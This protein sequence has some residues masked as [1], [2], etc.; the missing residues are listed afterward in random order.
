MPNS[1]LSFSI[2]PVQTFIES[3]RSVRDLWTGSYLLSWL[4]YH[5]MRPV[6][7][8]SGKKTDWLVFPAIEQHP[9][10]SSDRDC[11]SQSQLVTSNDLSKL[12]SPCL[13][14]RFL[15]S[16][17][18]SE[19]DTRQLAA[20]CEKSCRDEWDSI[21]VDTYDKIAEQIRERL[22]PSYHDQFRRELWDAQTRSFFDLQTTVIP[23]EEHGDNVCRK[24]LGDAFANESSLASDWSRSWTLLQS[25]FAASRSVRHVPA[26][27]HINTHV[28]GEHVAAKCSILGSYEQMGPSDLKVS[29][30][31]WS[32]F[33]RGEGGKGVTLNGIGTRAA[34]RF[35]AISLVKRFAF[36]TA[37]RPRVLK[38]TNLGNRPI[39]GE[40]RYPD[41]YTVAAAKWLN[42]SAQVAGDF[43]I[44]PSELRSWN[45][46]WLHWNQRTQEEDESSPSEA[47][48]RQIQTKRGIKGK[49][50]VPIYYAVLML[51]GDKMGDRLRMA[52]QSEQT[53]MS[54]LMSTFA[55]ELA[56]THVEE[57]NGVLIYSG[58]DDV[59]A[60]LPVET[61]L[62]CA[63]KLR[64]AFSDLWNSSRQER[65]TVS[66]GLAL[67][68]A[69][70]DL[71]LALGYARK[72]EKIAKNAGRD[73]LTLTTCRG[74]GEHSSAVLPWEFV[75][76]MNRWVN[77][78]LKQA[79]DRWA[80]RLAAEMNTWSIFND[81]DVL[82]S[83]LRR[84]IGRSDDETKQAFQ[85]NEPIRSMADD[86]QHYCELLEKWSQE[87]SQHCLV[88]VGKLFEQFIA[89]VQSAA[90]IARG[91]DQ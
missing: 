68:H 32:E 44:N 40:V 23:L 85:G 15:A 38:R 88:S 63:D 67:V 5:A 52:S 62:D 2:G 50:P 79:S 33:A 91:R 77:G 48:W 17:P 12:L 56:R 80:Y 55:L 13:P 83:E 90:F 81:V 47:L 87:K 1:L 65:V 19:G 22:P 84:Q 60:L 6:L 25:V 72:G 73:C 10:W 71:R 36:E 24:W 51:D 75:P 21:C 45:G 76:T 70:E 53:D 18:L 30:D 37:I 82:K 28:R 59:L 9:L 43:A 49:D 89:L 4:T 8:E 14:N 26:Y 29:T 3:A 20:D 35:C 46:Y 64:R 69:K 74:S 41:T 16:V 42:S 61:S 39:S 11:C 86:F 54:A 58:G 66:A 34:E 57:S 78:F 31:F 27:R 7:I